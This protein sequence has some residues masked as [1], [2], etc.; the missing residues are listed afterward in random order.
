MSKFK[1]V[2]TNFLGYDELF[3]GK[4]SLSGEYEV[5]EVTLLGEKF[6]SIAWI[7][8]CEDKKQIGDLYTEVF[9]D[10]YFQAIFSMG[11]AEYIN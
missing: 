5:Q 9:G 11:F 2:A 1:I 7:G 3:E 10:D 6:H 8:K 4:E